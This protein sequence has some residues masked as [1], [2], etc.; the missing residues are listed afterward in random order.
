MTFLICSSVSKLFELMCSDGCMCV[1][2]CVS[3]SSGMLNFCAVALALCDLGYRPMGV[4]LDSG[5]LCRQSV[6]VRRVF[7]LCSEQWVTRSA[8]CVHQYVFKNLQSE[9]I[10]FP[11]DVLHTLLLHISNCVFVFVFSISIASQILPLIH[12]LSLGPIT[13]QSKAWWSSTRR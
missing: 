5:D 4:R 8:T 7:R 6:D 12:S 1:C 11:P 3:F 2:A 10:L 9:M 13:S